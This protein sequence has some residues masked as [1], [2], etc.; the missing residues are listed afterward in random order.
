MMRVLLSLLIVLL[1]FLSFAQQKAAAFLPE[2]FENYPNVRDF[3]MSPDG[4]DIY[5]T[6]DDLKSRIALI[7]FM[8]KTKDGWTRP[9][10]VSFTGKYR[11][12]EAAFSPDG[13]RLYFVSNRP[14]HKDSVNPKDYD[15]WYVDKTLKGWS[16]PRNIGFPINTSAHE[17]YPSITNKG[18]IY[19]T[20]ERE[21]AIGREDI[22]VSRF[23]DGNYQEPTSLKGA[24]NTKYFEFNAYVAPD[25]TY[26]IFSGQR[27][28]EGK[29]RGELYISYNENGNWSEGK[30][31]EKINSEYL[32]FCPFVDKSSGKLYFTSQKTDVQRTY[33]EALNLNSFLKMYEQSSKGLNRIYSIDFNEVI[34]N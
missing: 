19:F 32:D 23:K 13:K 9:E 29:G 18:D 22:F 34:K 1:N 21:G 28:K 16:E 15:I 30:L 20:A 6:V 10:S 25:E 11:D 7:S 3:T 33:K 14:I 12:L 31:L 5:F 2:V 4:Q 17:F 24:L 8:K 26:I 27:P